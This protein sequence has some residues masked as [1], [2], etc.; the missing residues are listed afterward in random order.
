MQTVGGTEQV[1]QEDDQN[2]GQKNAGADQLESTGDD[3]NRTDKKHKPEP[4][5]N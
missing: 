2:A 1:G 4:A 5:T 3:A